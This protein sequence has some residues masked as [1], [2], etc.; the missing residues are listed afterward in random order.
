MGSINGARLP[1]QFRIDGRINK[2][3]AVA[4]GK[5]KSKKANMNVYC[6]VMNMLDARNVTGVYRA[7]G[8]PDDTGFLTAS[9][10]Q[11]L[12]NSQVNPASFIDLYS[13]KSASPFN[14]ALPRRIR[15]G[16]TLDF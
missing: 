2:N 5:E 4:F 13:M 11:S 10:S 15:L 16:L 12:I 1:W 14:Y 7:T 6:Q 9:Q 8:N 3:I